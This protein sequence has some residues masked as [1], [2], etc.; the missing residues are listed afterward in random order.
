[1]R[2]EIVIVVAPPPPE[3]DASI[4]DLDSLLRTALD[5]VSL[6]QAVAEIVAITGAPRRMIY[7]RALALRTERDDGR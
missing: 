6:K 4:A 7:Q 5:R 1:V 3:D 2:G